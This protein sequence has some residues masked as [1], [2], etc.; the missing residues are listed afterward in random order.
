MAGHFDGAVTSA[1]TIVYGV[2][3]SAIGTFVG[4]IAFSLGPLVVEQ[5]NKVHSGARM[6]VYTTIA[7]LLAMLLTVLWT[8]TASYAHSLQMS[9]MLWTVLLASRQEGKFWVERNMSWQG[10]KNALVNAWKRWTE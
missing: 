7:T 9:A 4:A 3:G 5:T 10:M 1:E 6:M 8:P 2:L